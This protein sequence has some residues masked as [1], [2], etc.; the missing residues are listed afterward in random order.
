MK[1]AG[2]DEFLALSGPKLRGP[3]AKRRS[4]IFSKWTSHYFVL[5]EGCLYYFKDQK[6]SSADAGPAGMIQLVEVDIRPV[7]ND[8]IQLSAT[9]GSLQY[10]KFEKKKP[11]EMVGHVQV[12]LLKA[13]SEKTRDK[14]LYRIRKSY[15]HAN[16]TG[17]VGSN[18]PGD[19]HSM[20]GIYRFPSAPWVWTCGSR[21]NPGC[22]L[23]FRPFSRLFS[24]L[25]SSKF[26]G[27]FKLPGY[28]CDEHLHSAE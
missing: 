3:L 18:P 27:T 21:C 4:G 28:D 15:V 12:L 6:A 22:F 23:D 2:G 11:P 7:D 9:K 1:H 25:F 14:W 19:L 20:S 26:T 5:T 10:V 8:K 17:E 13:S 24:G 16:F